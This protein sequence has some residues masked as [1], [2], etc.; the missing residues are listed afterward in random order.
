MIN[1]NST[2]KLADITDQIKKKRLSQCT[3]VL[4]H[5]TSEL[6]LVKK[7]LHSLLTIWGHVNRKLIPSEVSSEDN[8]QSSSIE[9][10]KT[11]LDDTTSNF[12]KDM[13]AM[14][15]D[16]A[17]QNLISRVGKIRRS[18]TE[19]VIEKSGQL[20]EVLKGIS[21]IE[22][23]IAQATDDFW[24]FLKSIQEIILKRETN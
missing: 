23:S 13:K 8:A 24:K 5:R 18:V 6:E 15:Q 16:A 19:G 3:E 1:G 22:S 2:E 11:K 20:D 10:M 21:G 17:L 7:Y 14:N 12:T 4:N 9:L